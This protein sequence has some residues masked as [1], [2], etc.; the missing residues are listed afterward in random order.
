MIKAAPAAA[1]MLQHEHEGLGT[2]ALGSNQL[3]FVTA[4]K[5]QTLKSMLLAAV[6]RQQQQQSSGDT[7]N[8]GWWLQHH[9][10]H[11][12]HHTATATPVI[13]PELPQLQHS[14]APHMKPEMCLSV[15]EWVKAK[16]SP[17]S[18]P[19]HIWTQNKDTES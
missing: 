13:M 9:A 8:D 1:D 11:T 5:I 14:A 12:G 6:H 16:F 7:D 18:I 2:W 4:L 10:Q 3:E 17:Y 15:N 19:I